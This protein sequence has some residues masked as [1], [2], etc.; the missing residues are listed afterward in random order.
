VLVSP[1]DRLARPGE[2]LREPPTER[3]TSEAEARPEFRVVPGRI[4]LLDNLLDHREHVSDLIAPLARTEPF[5]ALIDL[6]ASAPPPVPVADPYVITTGTAPERYTVITGVN[7]A[8][9]RATDELALFSELGIDWATAPH[10]VS[11]AGGREATSERGTS[12]A[13]AKPDRISLQTTGGGAD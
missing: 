6:I 7:A 9:R 5:T 10:V 3:G 4:S 11:F 2:E 1:T 13:E 12:E 8:I